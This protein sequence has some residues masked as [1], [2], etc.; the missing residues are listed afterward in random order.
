MGMEIISLPS[1]DPG[2]IAFKTRN[3]SYEGAFVIS[4]DG[5]HWEVTTGDLIHQIKPVQSGSESYLVHDIFD[6]KYVFALPD[7]NVQESGLKPLQSVYEEH[8]ERYKL[9]K[10]EK[11]AMSKLSA[12][13]LKTLFAG[14]KTKALTERV[15]VK[16]SRSRR[17]LRVSQKDS[18]K[19][20][21]KLQKCGTLD[22][23]RKEKGLLARDTFETGYDFD[24]V[25][26]NWC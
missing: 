14:S 17:R 26:L 4:A 9:R 24:K 12:H 5:N 19:V 25:E 22:K 3:V 13:Q 21:A 18:P 7:S 11:K 2:K 10:M 20:L 23:R 6:R 8:R 1:E 16:V 15:R